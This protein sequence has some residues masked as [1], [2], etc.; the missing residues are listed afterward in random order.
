MRT[1]RRVHFNRLPEV[2][3]QRF[4]ESLAGRGS[5]LVVSTGASFALAVVGWVFL[6]LSAAFGAFLVAGSEYGDPYDFRQSADLMVGY[7]AVGF[8]GAAAGLGLLRRIALKKSL[9]YAPGTYLFP[10]VL[11]EAP[12]TRLRLYPMNALQ[13]MKATHHYTN[14]VYTQTV[15]QFRF[16]GGK[17]KALSIA[18]KERAEQVGPLL[19]QYGQ[20]W[21]QAIEEKNGA[22]LAWLDPFLEARL[23]PETEEAARELP[24]V[25]EGQL[26]VRDVPWVLE[27]PWL[28]GLAV[29]AFVAFPAWRFR[30]RAS[31]ESA[32]EWASRID[33]P[34]TWERF[35][36]ESESHREEVLAERLPRAAFARIDRERSVARYREFIAAHRDHALA[37]EARQRVH[38]LYAE[39]WRNF[40]ARAAEDPEAR[41]AMKRLVDWLE[42][43][44]SPRVSVRFRP[45]TTDELASIDE[46]FATWFQAEGLGATRTLHP[47]AT[48]FT[49]EKCLLRE[50]AIVTQLQSGFGEVFPNDVLGLDH[51]EPI[52]TAEPP[53]AENPTIDVSYQVASSGTTYYSEDG[54][55][56]YVGIV[57]RFQ[58]TVRIPD[59]GAALSFDLEVE[60]PERFEV[61]TNSPFMVM[62][63]PDAGSVYD[64][65]AVKAF[66]ALSARLRTRFFKG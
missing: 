9:P 22:V 66:E 11:V 34:Q 48:H 49:V 28:V 8:L 1:I 2:V 52:R 55:G 33:D 20:Q 23:E 5:P 25:P 39:S 61:T 65:M 43:H 24:P 32:F 60:P 35:A 50:S 57:V 45:P 7:A 14:G 12:S 53:P 18:G 26:Q 64:V 3:R 21:N 46:A 54:R 59:G 6:G 40:E 62:G 37:A 17:K 13:D 41:A 15:I 44:D 16:D 58:V 31:E 4:V 30:N 47:M 56:V 51:G 38:D 36:A 42:A 63:D 19:S 27:H 29:G 10:M